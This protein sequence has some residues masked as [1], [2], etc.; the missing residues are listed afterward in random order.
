MSRLINTGDVATDVATNLIEDWIKLAWNKVKKYFKDIKIQEDI[1]LSIAYETYLLRTKEKYGK[2]KTLIYKRIK[3][4]L[5]SFYVHTRLKYGNKELDSSDINN[6]IE[7]TNKMIITGTGGIGKSTLMHHLFLNTIEKTD[8]IPVLIELRSLNT[9][10]NY[11]S[12]RNFIYETLTNNGFD[13]EDEYFEYSLNEGGYIFLFDGYDEMN[14]SI[15]DKATKDIQNFA[16]KYHKNHYIISSRPSS[17]F[18]GWNDFDELLTIPLSKEQAIELID[19][20]KYDETVKTKFLKELDNSLFDKHKSFAQNP[21]LLTIMLLTYESSAKIPETLNDFYERAFLVLFNEHDALKDVY[22]RETRTNLSYDKFK[23]VF[24]Y[25]CFAS[26]FENAYEF[27]DVS[28]LKYLNRAQNKYTDIIFN[29]EDY[30]ED[31]L[32]HVC[33]LV[34]DGL[35]YRFSHRSFQE[36]FAAVYTCQLTDEAQKSLF[37]K[38]LM[39]NA[40]DIESYYKMLFDMQRERFI[41]NIILPGLSKLK[42]ESN[43]NHSFCQTIQLLYD[44]FYIK[45]SSDNKLTWG[46]SRTIDDD[47]DFYFL[48]IIHLCLTLID[49]VYEPAS[50]ELKSKQEDVVKK[51]LSDNYDNIERH[52]KYRIDFS[53]LIALDN[54]DVELIFDWIKKEYLFAMSLL[55]K[56]S[57]LPSE[58][59][60]LSDL[61]AR[62]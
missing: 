45:K 15:M 53:T 52:R 51:L 43:N 17:T 21:L 34:K 18:I 32:Q 16:D 42:S 55:D 47:N 56:Y 59:T 62:L 2:I 23:R 31:L 14:K 12:I 22:E 26:Y 4:D 40:S 37:E 5:Y 28:L 39:K 58:E 36:Y 60:S 10:D 3:E 57:D 20:I 54:A 9:M 44:E 30:Q 35:L 41:K 50:I 49:Y 13:L 8:Y 61:I 6:L 46:L 19:K 27:T 33:M 38:R 29:V 25:I 24:S 1:D 48:N 7:L 11:V